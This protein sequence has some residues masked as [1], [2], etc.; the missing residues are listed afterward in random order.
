M[1]SVSTLRKQKGISSLTVI[2][3]LS[4]AALGWWGLGGA[5]VWIMPPLTQSLPD[6]GSARA[7]KAQ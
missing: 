3:F 2:L 7:D 4:L 6:W 5:H 1:N